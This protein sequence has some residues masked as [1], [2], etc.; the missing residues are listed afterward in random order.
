MVGL[1]VTSTQTL[2]D[3]MTPCSIPEQTSK[4]VA[5]CICRVEPV[6]LSGQ[7]AQLIVLPGLDP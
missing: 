3:Y 6:A 1:T 7:G 5:L 4:P 2:V